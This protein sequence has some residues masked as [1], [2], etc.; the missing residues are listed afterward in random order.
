MQKMPSLLTGLTLKQIEA[1]LDGR[2]LELTDIVESA[3]DTPF[4][5]F[6]A[7]FGL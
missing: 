1:V 5:E 4:R 2:Q 7:H 6:N 3:E